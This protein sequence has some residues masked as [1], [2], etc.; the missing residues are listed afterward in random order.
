MALAN[1]AL[2]GGGFFAPVVVGKLSA[3]LG[4]EWSFK[5]VAI[6]AGALYPLIFFFVPETAYRRS[7]DIAVTRS[8]GHVDLADPA[9]A[10][11]DSPHLEAA[12]GDPDAISVTELSSPAE[13]SRAAL[14][15]RSYTESLLPFNG[16]KTDEDFYKI[17]LRPF[18]LF[19]HPAIGWAVL[20][21]GS[22]IGW[23]VFIG[24]VLAVVLFAPPL[25]FSSVQ[26]GY[27]Y[28]SAIIGSICGFIFCGVLSDWSAKT[29]A[30]WNNGIFEVR[31]RGRGT[32]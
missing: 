1:L 31:M 29:M 26:V 2:F 27:M 23:T 8:A 28:A 19:F 6:I 30:R 20:T 7:E 18:P 10:S 24:I 5:L 32:P 4:W 16:R 25:F 15:R 14:P 22:I 13:S 21:Q 17:L 11:L 3:S 12:K 9:F